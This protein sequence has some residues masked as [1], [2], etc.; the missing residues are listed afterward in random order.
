LETPRSD[1]FNSIT[2]EAPFVFANPTT[3]YWAEPTSE[4][5]NDAT[6]E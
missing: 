6:G 2:D 5:L 1:F 3:V 4:R